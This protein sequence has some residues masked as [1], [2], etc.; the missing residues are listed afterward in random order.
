MILMDVQDV[1]SYLDVSRDY[2]RWIREDNL[3][4]MW[5]MGNKWRTSLDD[6]NEFLELTRGYDMS[7]R[8]DVRT[9]ALLHK[10]I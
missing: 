8:A 5:K 9:F 10:R 6:V 7:G 1:M 4:K 3:L 2:V